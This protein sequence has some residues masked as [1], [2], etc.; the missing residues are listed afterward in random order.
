MPFRIS[1]I[2]L[3]VLLGCFGCST[4]PKINPKAEIQSVLAQ[5][6][7]LKTTFIDPNKSRKKPEYYKYVP[8]IKRIDV[9]RCP[10]EFQQTWFDYVVALEQAHAHDRDADWEGLGKVLGAV[11]AVQTGGAALVAL[12]GLASPTS[13]SRLKKQLFQRLE[14][15]WFKLE[16]ICLNYGVA[17]ER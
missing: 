11:A 3:A 14:D 12:P 6:Q 10:S 4:V 17:A 16:R 13:N 9:S 1:Q 5:R 7:A 2:V 8:E 15:A